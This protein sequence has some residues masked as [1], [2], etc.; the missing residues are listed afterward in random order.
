MKT[1]DTPE[2][3][4]IAVKRELKDSSDLV[5][6]HI[7]PKFTVLY[8]ANL[9]DTTV[10]YDYIITPLLHH[11][12]HELPLEQLQHELPI[13]K[14]ITVNHAT[15]AIQSLLHGWTLLTRAGEPEGLLFNTSNMPKRSV[16]AAEIESNVIG[17]QLA[18][19]ESL[20]TNVAIIRNYVA[21]PSLCNESMSVGTRTQTRLNLMYMKDLAEE[22]TVNS[23]RQRITDLEFDGVISSAVLTQLIDDNSSTL[24]PQML[25]TERPDRVGLS[26]LEGKVVLVVD[27]SSLAIIAPSTFL[28]FFK[29]P[30]DH[31]SHWNVAIFV[32][33]LRLVAIFLSIF[34][35]SAYV[36]A[37]TFHYEV[38]PQSLLVPLA[39][40]RSRVP[41]PPLFESLFLEITI[42]LLRE[43][44][45]R[46]PTKVG[47]TMGIVGGIVIG[48]AAVQAG[49]TSNILI[50]LVALAALS[51]FTAPNYMM[52][53]SLRFLR[54][55]M[56][57]VAGIWGG[58]G[59]MFAA[60]LLLIHLLRQT[61][62]GHPYLQPIYPL[63]WRELMDSVI[64]LPF[65]YLS[66][67]SNANRSIDKQRF[68][69]QKAAQKK[70]IDE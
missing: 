61:S 59:I 4:E 13:G 56:I 3:I 52:G 32:R 68:N 21:H 30:E 54:F 38:I 42:E 11:D 65:P 23:L 26:I 29:S 45:A 7:P 27:G 41:F 63:R 53:I 16:T 35:T 40:S 10:L 46:L 62:V 67:R 12:R 5:A 33:V 36:A 24:F 51:S 22:Q 37:L 58:I 34:L 20:D 15:E 14:A 48:Q 43:A 39:Q 64:R 18:F 28:D 25:L 57:V 19:T 60:C 70:D 47:Q 8:M 49:F 1:A 9:I 55:P 2:N 44:G 66:S 17:P 31:Y 6:K 69:P 50:M